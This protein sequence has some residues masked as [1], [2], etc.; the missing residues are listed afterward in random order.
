MLNFIN[1][2]SIPLL[3]KRNSNIDK[4]SM[5]MMLNTYN[6][7]LALQ[8]KYQ[9]ELKRNMQLYDKM[10]QS[11]SNLCQK[12][13][14][15]LSIV[16]FWV[17]T[18]LTEPCYQEN[19]EPKNKKRI[20]W[21][22]LASFFEEKCYWVAK[23][24]C[25]EHNKECWEEYLCIARLMIYN[26]IKLGNVLAKYDSQKGN[27][28][29][30][31]ADFLTKNIRAEAVVHKFSKW[32]LLCKKSD[33]ELKEALQ[34]AGICEP[35]IS[36]MLFARKYFKQVYVMSK[37]ENPARKI[38]KKWPD[39]EQEDFEISAR[40]YNSEKLMPGTP[41]EVYASP[42]GITGKQLQTWMD[43]CIVALQNYP[44]SIVPQH[45]LEALQSVG[46][47]AHSNYV[48]TLE[49]NSDN[50][51]NSQLSQIDDVDDNQDFLSIKSSSAL[52]EKLKEMKQD[53]QKVLFLYYGF[54]LTQKQLADKLKINQSSI[55]R[56]Q[57]K[58]LIILLDT[59]AGISQP[60]QW[61]KQYVE[62][63]LQRDYHVPSHSDLIQASLVSAV[64]KL[65]DAEHNILQLFYGQ[66]MDVNIIS[67]LVGISEIEV[68]ELITKLNQQLQE[69]LIQEINIWIKEYLER[70]LTKYYKSEAKSL[71]KALSKSQNLDVDDKVSLV[72]EYFSSQRTL[73]F[74][75]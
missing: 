14:R 51:D 13:D 19:W 42:G 31:I 57:A 37:V 49:L 36:Q 6:N 20:A 43:S 30:Y 73:N 15:G 35:E 67:S 45:S 16:Q 4:F 5:Y 52:H 63:W 53:Y 26:P 27:V 44:K 68:T 7:R 17:E 39:P 75:L 24:L 71:L 1:L 32:R 60:Q 8:W 59:L 65:P 22:H 46:W 58:S 55:S 10:N 41:H 56:Y 62:R 21:E 72:E 47:E 3:P 69:S 40:C 23:D 2:E 29:T 34:V 70:W 28:E 18:A 25:K 38:G 11:F 66:R 9:P 33:K 54:N 50:C 64:K 61:V 48:D 12:Q 74:R